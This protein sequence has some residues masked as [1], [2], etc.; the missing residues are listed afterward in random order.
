[1]NNVARITVQRRVGPAQV[2]APATL[3]AWATAAMDRTA[4]EL[5]IR[6]VDEEEGRA[7]NARYR[8]TPRATNVLSFGYGAEPAPD[9]PPL[10][11]DLVLCKPVVL[12]EAREQKIAPR[13]H[14]AH[15]VVH[16]VL[17]LRGMDHQEPEQAARMEDLERRILAR[18]GFPDPYSGERQG[19][20]PAR[21]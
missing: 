16:G 10:L 6:V 1:M 3:R 13:A 14:W 20:T 4:A 9:L 17:H 15:L 2:P 18:L 21:A 19:R 12:R 8:H 5:T 11:G 7:L